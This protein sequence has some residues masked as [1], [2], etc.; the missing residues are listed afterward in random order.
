MHVDEFNKQSTATNEW[1]C[2]ATQQE[3]FW[4]HTSYTI[5]SATSHQSK[6][7]SRYKPAIE[8]Q[9]ANNENAA[10]QQSPSGTQKQH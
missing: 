5:A 3:Q 1:L 9:W 10:T 6:P 4:P 7:N 2:C 8:H